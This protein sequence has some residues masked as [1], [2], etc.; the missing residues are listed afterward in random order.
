MEVHKIRTIGSQIELQVITHLDKYLTPE[1]RFLRSA[2]LDRYWGSTMGGSWIP[3]PL[4]LTS[5]VLSGWR[6]VGM[7]VNPSVLESYRP[8][9][10]RSSSSYLIPRISA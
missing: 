5:P 6:R 8:A 9:L 1:S 4:N 7:K 10:K 3:T 2:S